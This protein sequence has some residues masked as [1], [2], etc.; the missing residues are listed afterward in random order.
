MVHKY[1]GHTVDIIY[2]DKRQ[3]ITK[4]R[5]VIHA[6]RAGKIRAFCLTAGAPR[7]F[8]MANLLAVQPVRHHAG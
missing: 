2:M 4:R 5:I 6:I 8:D 7:T 3:R 1:I